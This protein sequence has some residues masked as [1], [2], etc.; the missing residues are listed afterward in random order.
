MSP[1]KSG[2]LQSDNRGPSGK[3]SRVEIKY[4]V[5]SGR[6]LLTHSHSCD[7]PNVISR[8]NGRHGLGEFIAH[9]VAL[10]T[11]SPHRCVLSDCSDHVCCDWREHEQIIVRLEK[12]VVAHSPVRGYVVGT[13]W[14]NECNR[15][16]TPSKLKLESQAPNS[17]LTVV[18]GVFLIMD[19]APEPSSGRP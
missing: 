15:Q 10:H 13:S 18:V 7:N 12:D 6:P 14:D 11:V 4:R 5:S 17:H 16:D 3:K 19:W 2:G 9:R 8:L 1:L